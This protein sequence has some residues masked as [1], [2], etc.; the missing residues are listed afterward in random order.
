MTRPVENDSWL[1]ADSFRDFRD[2]W[3]C[4]LNDPVAPSSTRAV[5]SSI[6]V[7]S[8]VRN[9]RVSARAARLMSEYS[10][11]RSSAGVLPGAADAAADGEEHQ[12][13]AQTHEDHGEHDV[14]EPSWSRMCGSIVASAS[15]LLKSMGSG[16][17]FIPR[18]LIGGPELHSAG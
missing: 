14:D 17:Y 7:W 12:P 16:A 8:I 10:W 9:A 2:A 13:A 1:A 18:M 11:A 6:L 15:S 3:Y 4:F 5:S